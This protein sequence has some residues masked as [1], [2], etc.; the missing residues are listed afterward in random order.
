MECLTMAGG[1]IL[2]YTLAPIVRQVGYL[3]F[4]NSNLKELKE[5]AESLQHARESV[6]QRVD[7]AYR[8]GDEIY[9]G[10]LGWLKKVDEIARK[11]EGHIKDDH[12]KKTGC[13]SRS[14]PNLC[15]RHKLSRKSKKMV[16]EVEILKNEGQFKHVSYQKAPNFIQNLPSAVSDED[17]GSRV[18]TLEAIMEALRDPDVN[19]IGVYGMGGVGKS[20]LATQVA[21]KAQQEFDVVVMATITQ[22]P[23]VEKIQG[24][25]ADML[26]LNFSSEQSSIGRAGRLH[27]RLKKEKNVLL[28]LDD[29]W[30]ELNWNEIGI[31]SPEEHNNKKI[32]ISSD[33]QQRSCKFLMISRDREFLSNLKLH[34]YFMVSPLSKIEAWKLFKEK[35]IL[36]ES[37]CNAELLSVAHKVAEECG[38]LPL[39]IVIIASSLKNKRKSEWNVVLEELRN[40]ASTG[41]PNA[42]YRSIEVS[43]QSLKDNILQSLFL[44]CG[45]VDPSDSIEYLFKC[46]VG[47]DLFEHFPK[48]KNA[49]NKFK[50]CIRKLKD[51]FLLLDTN[52]SNKFYK[53]HDVVRDVAFLIASKREHI[54]VKR[55]EILEGWPEEEQMK[56]YKTIIIEFC[57]LNGPLERLC[58]L[59]LT[60]LLINNENPSLKLSDDL[61][62]GMPRLKVLDLTGMKFESLPSSIS[63]LG[64]L[65][66]LC[67]DQCSLRKIEVIGKL[68][69]LK[70]L[71]LLKS[72]IKQLPEELGQLTQLQLLDLTGC[73][74]LKLIPPN[75]LSSLT[76]LEEL[77]MEDSFVNWDVIYPMEQQQ[78]N[79]SVS[80]LDNLPL[81]TRLVVH[82]PDERML[83]KVLTFD[84]HKKYKI[85]I[86]N[87][88]DWPSETET[89]RILK[90]WL[91]T[92]IHLRDDI[93]RLLDTVKELHIGKL[94][95]AKNVFPSL[96]NE[97]LPQLKH[98]YVTNNDEIQCVINSLGVIHSID[99]FP[100]LESMVLQNVMNLERLCS[101]PFTGESFSKLK[102]IK[103]KNCGNLRSLFSASLA[104]GLP[105]LVEIQL[106][107]CLRMERVVYDDEKA[108][109]ILPFPKLCSL[110]IQ[111]L[112]QLLGF[113]YE[114]NV[115]GTSDALFSEKVMFPSLEKLTIDGMDKLNMIWNRLMAEEDDTHS[116]SICHKMKETWDGQIADGSFCNLKTL[117]VANCKRISKV[118][119]FSLLNR[120]N[121]LE[122]LEV[123]GCNSVEV[124]FDL[125]KITS[126]ERHVVPKCHLRKLILISL[127]SLKHVWNK[128]PQGI[129][130][131]QNLSIIKAA[132]CQHMNYLLPVSVAKNLPNL[133]EL[134]LEN[135]TGLE[136]IVAMEEGLDATVRFM[137]PKVTL[138]WLWDLPKFKGF[139]PGGYITMWPQLR[140]LVYLGIPKEVNCFGSKYLCFSE[141]RFED[142]PQALVQQSA[143]VEEV[144]SNLQELVLDHDDSALVTWLSKHSE[145]YFSKIKVL[146]LQHFQE[147]QMSLSYSFFQRISKLEDLVVAHNSFEEIFAHENQAGDGTEHEN[148]VWVKNLYLKNLPKL[149]QIC[150]EGYNV[151]LNDLIVQECPCLLNLMPSSVILS[152][153]TSLS[154]Y[155][156]E[157]LL[158]LVVPSTAKT[159]SQLTVM[160]IEECKMIKEILA[161]KI[162]ANAEEGDHEITFK[163]MKTIK[164][165]SLPLLESFSSGN[166]AFKFPSLENALIC[167]CPNLKIFSKGVSTT[168]KLRRVHVELE[169]VDWYWEGDLNKTAQKMYANKVGLRSF[170]L[171]KQEEFPEFKELWHG[172]VSAR[173]FKNL[174]SIVVDS[175]EFVSIV[176]PF[177]VLKALINLEELEVKNCSN[178]EVVFLLDGEDIDDKIAILTTKL[179]KLMLSNLPNLKHVW[180]KDYRT[181]TFKNL[182]GVHVFNC[183]R[184]SY[185]FPVNVAKGLTQ[186]G[187]LRIEDCGFEEIVAKEEGQAMLVTFVF[188]KLTTLRIWRVPKLKCFYP[189]EHSV[190]WSGLRSLSI[191]IKS[192]VKVFGT[193]LFSFKEAHQERGLDVST[194]Q[195]IFLVEKAFPNLEELSLNNTDSIMKWLVQFSMEHFQKLKILCLQYFDVE[196]AN[197]PYRTL[198]RMPRLECLALAHSSFREIFPHKRYMVE[199]DQG[200]SLELFKELALWNLPKLEH[201]CEEGSKLS[202]Y[203]MNLQY[204]IVRECCLLKNLVPSSVSFNNLADLDICSCHGLV[205]L[206]TSSTAK[207]LAQ[208]R[209]MKIMECNMI[210]EI[211]TSDT[212]ECGVEI[213]F[214][215]LEVLELN[216]L[217]SLRSFCSG[218]YDFKFPCLVN[219]IVWQCPEMRTFSQRVPSTPSLQRVH[220]DGPYWEGNL[221]ATI[222]MIYKKMVNENE[223][224]EDHP[225]VPTTQM[226][227]MVN[228]YKVDESGEVLDIIEPLTPSG[229]MQE[230]K[231]DLDIPQQQIPELEMAPETETAETQ[232][233]ASSTISG[234]VHIEGVYVQ[235]KDESTDTQTIKASLSDADVISDQNKET[236]LVWQTED[237]IQDQGVSSIIG[238]KGTTLDTSFMDIIFDKDAKDSTLDDEGGGVLGDGNE[239]VV[240][241]Q[242]TM[243]ISTSTTVTPSSGEIDAATGVFYVEPTS[244]DAVSGYGTTSES[245][246]ASLPI[247]PV[248]AD[249]AITNTN[250]TTDI[251][252][253]EGLR[254][255]RD[256]IELNDEDI[257]LVKQAV[258]QYPNLLE[259]KGSFRARFYRLAY[260]TLAELLRF[261]NTESA[262]TITQEREQMFQMMCDEAIQFGF[263]RKWVEEMRKRVARDPE[264]DRAQKRLKKLRQ[265][266]DMLEEFLLARNKC[267]RSM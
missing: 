165:K 267:F 211:V 215:K 88:W 7:A 74:Q 212:V 140:K 254:K 73:S 147:E 142:G 249:S 134:V 109:G 112:P 81:L 24:Q 255:F 156:C 181:V 193:K 121:N 69:G 230:E 224:V 66:T 44:L 240:Y 70:V 263:D 163:K 105:Q 14:F 77:Y 75:T 89:S 116:S 17:F 3:I 55:N 8:N 83:P 180:N 122:E 108:A 195:P 50:S 35:A 12:H 136:N 238:Q 192:E 169:V 128:D 232:K 185:L 79:A 191:Y 217:S 131:F 19:K 125:A 188:P 26:R 244:E 257:A 37:N 103:V 61:F 157:G 113:H 93:K 151:R 265:E 205:H 60:F 21:Q 199:G 117:K 97:G 82:I 124:V 46:S 241:G 186:L 259:I 31:P 234:A 235:S 95:G 104:R 260:K 245:V 51:S 248:S 45:I 258:A 33:T 143:A 175:C 223:L 207:S 247:P 253:P 30:G 76:N 28:I 256:I 40:P 194:Q 184:L 100:N 242:G 261:L 130:D 179:K 39:A 160:M 22:N 251:A 218:K 210:E 190:D 148:V 65:R 236:S 170:E 5:K 2:D 16:Q 174:R 15:M 206:V 226:G 42:I 29:L 231:Y 216:K 144:I 71:S 145:N 196:Q 250:C 204:L 85:L 96:N 252:F 201:I 58:C 84:R 27:E 198:Q 1:K 141:S 13:S 139:Y 123:Q 159:L 219:I 49:R 153:L 127:P 102:I 52:S 233:Q 11:V 107:D 155:K 6:Q 222:Y 200:D 25:I 137:F 10:V 56:N 176:V 23:E 20:T 158:Y 208:L 41:V 209:T 152:H 48:V 146:T 101:G 132:D 54:F 221:N 9:N 227:G 67:L 264:V 47:L 126:E 62:E 220:G 189:G 162:N 115:L 32:S 38:G 202:Q 133:L 183:E 213:T 154:I 266:M 225:H 64:S 86:G 53:I 111:S 214:T 172:Q 167:E 262:L 129:L 171:L 68:K 59:N 34:K 94:E 90:L 87:V 135:C 182:Q 239:V 92:S 138:L 99:L 168:P 246:C 229:G 57:D 43:Y 203:F 197:I 91:S 119:S 187:E 114:G 118:L 243:S 228:D 80:E 177:N 150:K 120:L 161:D 63:L 166:Y 98:L 110:T 106:E 149:R 164:L 18:E 78:S 4:Y 72:D 173:E 237:S 178:A 36:D